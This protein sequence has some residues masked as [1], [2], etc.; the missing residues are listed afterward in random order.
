MAIAGAEVG[1]LGAEAATLGVEAGVL[2]KPPTEQLVGQ[3]QVPTRVSVRLGARAR[4]GS[5]AISSAGVAT[6]LA[7]VAIGWRDAKRCESCCWLVYV[8]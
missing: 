5:L 6:R 7:W 4:I 2:A 1:V 8:R 3:I